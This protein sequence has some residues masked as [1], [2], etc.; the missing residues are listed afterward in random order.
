MEA[1][2]ALLKMLQFHCYSKE[3]ELVQT[4][5]VA[6]KY[7]RPDTNQGKSKVCWY[8][9]K[10]STP[11]TVRQG[12]CAEEILLK[13]F[14]PAHIN[15]YEL[16]WISEVRLNFFF[17]QGQIHIQTW[18]DE[19]W[20]IGWICVSW[21]W[22][23]VS[24]NSRVFIEWGIYKKFLWDGVT[25]NI[26]KIQFSCGY[27]S[28]NTCT[29]ATVTVYLETKRYLHIAPHLALITQRTLLLCSLLSQP[30]CN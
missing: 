23:N 14:M 7:Y 30:Q 11:S 9:R 10:L 8:I 18:S 26:P 3:T 20:I 16:F 28:Q 1:L 15:K 19:W 25:W 5:T 24:I 6:S 4:K 29:I 27:L 22:S 13:S 12:N 17:L 2:W 21:K